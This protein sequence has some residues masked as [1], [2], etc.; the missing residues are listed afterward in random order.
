MAMVISISNQKGGTGKSTMCSHLAAWL[1]SIGY[2]VLM[3]DMD[4]QGHLSSLTGTPKADGVFDL[5]VNGKEL[6]EV[7]LPITAEYHGGAGW[8]GLLPGY[9]RTQL[10]AIDIQLSGQDF[11]RLGKVLQPLH[12]AFDFI[13][14]DNSPTVSLFTPSI[15]MASDYVII[16][17]RMMTLD[18]NGVDEIVQIMTNLAALH[19]AKLLGIIPTQ[20]T[21]NT[22][23][24][25]LQMTDLREKYGALV[26]DDCQT[27]LSTVWAE[28]SAVA[29]PVF[30]YHPEHQATQQA[31]ILGRRV[32]QHLGVHHE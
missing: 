20:C 15:L 18:L 7:I 19:N 21:P 16:P 1:A 13:L 22:R 6:H 5:L 28:A 31:Q 27:T 26:W 12:S 25:R 4:P 2:K 11:G 8:L 10:A 24:Y 29:R 30:V 32:L 9:N 14:F 3:I 23:E 17:T